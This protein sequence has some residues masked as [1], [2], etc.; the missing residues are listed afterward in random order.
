MAA[1]PNQS[2]PGL[3]G[4]SFFDRFIA[5]GFFSGFFP[6]APGTAGSAAALLFF[7]IPGF[8]AWYVLI[9]ASVI[10]FALGGRA[11]GKA[12]ALLGQDPSFVTVDEVV[13]MWTSLWLVPLTVT[14]AAAAFFLFRLFDI[15]KPSP[16]RWFDKKSGGWNIMLDDVIAAVYTNLVLQIA[17]RVF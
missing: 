6:V 9:P 10:L 12:E 3:S 2:K 15:I 7:L 8:S 13:G 11:A 5:T 14:T 4:L 16:A 17:V 1:S